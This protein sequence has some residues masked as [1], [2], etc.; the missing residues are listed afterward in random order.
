MTKKGDYSIYGQTLSN[1][2]GA[3]LGLLKKDDLD[4]LPWGKSGEERGL[5]YAG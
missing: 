3:G 1:R 2:A 5:S 4:S